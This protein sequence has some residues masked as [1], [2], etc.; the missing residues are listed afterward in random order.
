[1]SRDLDEVRIQKKVKDKIRGFGRVATFYETD[2]ST[3][4]KWYIS[5]PRQARIQDP[6]NNH[7]SASLVCLVAALDIPLTLE[8]GNR[9]TDEKTS[10]D[11][12]IIEVDPIDSGD[13]TQAFRV[14]LGR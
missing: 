2:D 11:Y 5:P 3:D 8:R 6:D 1:M 10:L 13:Y 12:R 4:H 14:W 7:P 9:M